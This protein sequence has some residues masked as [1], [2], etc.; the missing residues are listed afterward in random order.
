MTG[1][2]Q[3]GILTDELACLT[4]RRTFKFEMRVKGD[5]IIAIKDN[6]VDIID[7]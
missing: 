2:G 1:E 6:R 7:K 5:D 3:T 4:T